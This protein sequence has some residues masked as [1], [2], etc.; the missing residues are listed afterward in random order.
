MDDAHEEKSRWC[1]REYATYKD[2]SVFAAASDVD[3]T[4]LSP[5]SCATTQWPHSV[6]L[7]KQS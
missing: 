4:F 3:N 7:L 1:A 6:K 2:P 5:A